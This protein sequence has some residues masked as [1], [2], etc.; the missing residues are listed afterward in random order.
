MVV[1]EHVNMNHA[2]LKKVDLTNATIYFDDIRKIDLNSLIIN[3]EHAKI[4]IL[5]VMKSDISQSGEIFMK[6]FLF[7]LG[8][9]LG[10]IF[11]ST[12]NNKKEVLEPYKKFWSGIKK[13]VKK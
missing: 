7:V 1:I 5:L 11:T 10:L 9:S 6:K 4:L 2:P 3:K 12:E 8:L 13:R